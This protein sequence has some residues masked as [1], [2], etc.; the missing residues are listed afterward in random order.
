MKTIALFVFGLICW[1]LLTNFQFVYSKAIS[2]ANQ[3]DESTQVVGSL[4]TNASSVVEEISKDIIG[5]E[6]N[7]DSS[8]SGQDKVG[9]LESELSEK[10]SSIQDEKSANNTE[11]SNNN[12]LAYAEESDDILEKTET[13]PE[14]EKEIAHEIPEEP[15]L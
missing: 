15:E 10:T 3:V 8:N 2:I 7:V 9:S 6:L 11:P 13:E 12:V 1:L 4:D 14:L 5:E